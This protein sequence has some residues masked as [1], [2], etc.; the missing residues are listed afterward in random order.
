[1]GTFI[2]HISPGLAFLSFGLLYASRFSWMVMSGG[3]DQYPLRAAP[4][5]G[6]LRKLPLE[7]V[8]KLV[9]GMLALLAEFFFPPGVQKLHIFQSNDPEFRFQNPNEWQHATMYGAFCLSGALDVV[10]QSCLHRRCP[11]LEHMGVTAAFFI[12]TL[13]LRF[14]AH[15]KE[16]V[17]VHVHSLLLL[18]CALTCA[19]LTT[20]IWL[21]NQRR[22]WF[23]KTWLVLVQG[24]WL[25]HAAFILYRPP[26]GRRWD[27]AVP[28]DLMFLTTFYCWHL[29]LDAGLLA[30]VFWATS[31]L[32][33]RGRS[34]RDDYRL[35]GEL[36][37]RTG[38]EE[39]DEGL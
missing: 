36:G 6:F 24:T 2:G 23:A 19:I 39:G 32:H 13:L 33:R 11:L 30:A 12:T 21:P 22:L 4:S 17:E 5:Q 8:M 27:E 31:I 35:V 3:R 34:V 1:M 26:T 37:T 16:A 7:G 9:Y 29:A 18:T 20:E 25:L 15:G 10:S 14:H 28:A 38:G